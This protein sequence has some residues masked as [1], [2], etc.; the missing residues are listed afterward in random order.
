[1]IQLQMVRDRF[2]DGQADRSLC[3]HLDSL[4]AN[5]PM[6]E[7]ADSCRIW[8]RHCEPEIRPRM[9]MDRGP[10]HV[11]AQVSEE[12]PTPAIPP[13]MECAE[14]TIRKLL[15]TPAP[16]PLQAAPKYTDRDILVRQLME[17]IYP[18]DRP[19]PAIPSEMESVEDTIRR[20]LPTPA[21]LPLQAAPKYTDRDTIV[22]QLMETICTEDRP[23]PAIPSEMESVDDTIRRLL[24]TP[25]P[26]PLQAAPK[27]T[28]RDNLVQQLRET[29]CPKMLVAQKRQPTNDWEIPSFNRFPVRRRSPRK[30]AFHAGNG[31]I[32]R[33][34]V[35]L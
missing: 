23:T 4:G 12:G 21:P 24:P 35:R 34:N 11:T 7:M 16:P 28:D 25:A 5:T 10:I 17:T 1:M 31:H 6:I 32:I 2:I 9:S 30:G 26:P 18:E 14:D 29:I 19:I 22:Q 33:N 8:E 13:E 27:Y 15:P 20:L 3:R